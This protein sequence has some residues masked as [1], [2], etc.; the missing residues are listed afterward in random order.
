MDTKKRSFLGRCFALA[1]CAISVAASPLGA[2][3][4][5]VF[6]KPL[7][8]YLTVSQT[9]AFGWHDEYDTYKGLRQA[10]ST[11]IVEGDYSP[12]DNIKMYGMLACTADLAYVFNRDSSEWQEKGFD[13]SSDNLAID[14]EYW[15]ILKEFHATWTSGNAMVRVGK[16]TVLWG[17]LIY[18]KLL[19]Q[20]NANDGIRGLTDLEVETTLIPNWLLRADYAIPYS[21]AMVSDLNFQ[22]V[23]NPNVDPDLFYH[24]LSGNTGF[25][26][27][28]PYAKAGPYLLGEGTYNFD[29]PEAWKDGKIA[30]RLQ[31]L[32]GNTMASINFV[33]GRDIGFLAIPDS[34]RTTITTENGQ[35]LIHGYYDCF[36]PIRK[37]VGGMFA[38]ELTDIRWFNMAAPMLRVEWSYQWDSTFTRTVGAT[39][40]LE[41]HDDARLG[42]SLEMA[43]PIRWLNPKNMVKLST[44]GFVKRISGIDD[45]YENVRGSTEG[46]VQESNYNTA[47]SLSSS[48]HAGQ[49]TPSFTWI[50]DWT[51]D[52]NI[53][54]PTIS[55]V[56]S[57]RWSFSLGVTFFSGRKKGQ[58]LE[59]YDHKDNVSFKVQYKWG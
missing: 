43:F 35:P 29:T 56:P 32:I 58:G 52:S 27:W 54:K 20:I 30:V 57:Y 39:T 7:T 3:E 24:P 25:G 19:D 49:I 12:V 10:L 51:N 9:A 4:I 46:A 47:M 40:T 44:I 34:T 23:Y 50:Q 8:Y 37:M 33:F 31:G 11:A 18:F 21:S 13:A 45:G 1:L 36:F 59:I 22:L 17:E 55:Y 28:A 14:S 15:R 2:A 41:E 6:D 5:S 48:Y 53:M 38:T 16:Q 42:A 26:V